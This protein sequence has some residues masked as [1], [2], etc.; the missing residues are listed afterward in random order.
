MRKLLQILCC[1]G[2]CALPLEMFPASVSAETVGDG[3]ELIENVEL[4]RGDSALNNGDSADYR[5]SAKGSDQT[6]V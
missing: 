6:D 2:L 5:R 4:L 3:A 1:I